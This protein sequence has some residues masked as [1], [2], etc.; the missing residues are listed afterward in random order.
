MDP[1]KNTMVFMAITGLCLLAACG[2]FLQ[3]EQATPESNDM[4]YNPLTP[5]EERVIVRKGTEAPFTG[6]FHDHFEKGVYLCRRCDSPLYR[7]EDKFKSGCGWPS[8]DDEI[9]GAIKRQ[10]DT[11][12]VRTEILCA[13]CDAH[14]GHV[15]KG[16][17]MT[18]KNTRHCVNSI[19]M[20]FIP[21]EKLGR[22]VFAGG[23]FWGVEHHFENV[24]GVI[25]ATSGYTGGHVKNPTYRQVCAGG[26]GHVEA[27]EIVYLKDKVSYETLARLF[28]EIHDPTQADGQGPDRGSQ[29]LSVLFYENEEQKK[30]AQKL[31]SML[32]EKGLDVQT[33]IEKASPFYPAEEYHQDY[34][35][36]MGKE[37]YCH[38]RVKRF[39]D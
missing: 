10:T 31:V 5:E 29:Y 16:E 3:P 17:R 2:I 30:T 20:D 27:V 19:S 6:E 34:Y 15:F 28:F 37:P 13:N 26:T 11:D 32:K 33:K 1:M 25:S 36:K 23:C 38:N 24:E 12:G 9:P 22:A 8:F 35:E 4:T 7:S 18:E 21:A 14:L 39:D